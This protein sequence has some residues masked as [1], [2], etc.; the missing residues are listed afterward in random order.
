M[1][2]YKKKFYTIF[3]LFV[4]LWCFPVDVLADIY[5]SC[6]GGVLPEG[7]DTTGT[8]TTGKPYRT[9]QVGI[10]ALKQ[11]GPGNILYLGGGS[12][13][14]IPSGSPW[15]S[16][17]ISFETLNDATSWTNSYTICSYPG[18]WA[19][20]DASSYTEEDRIF[21]F[22]GSDS[23]GG[24]GFIEF[25]RLEIKG[26]HA[27][28]SCAGIRGRGGPYKFRY[29]YIHD[30]T[31]DTGATN[32]AGLQL[33]NGTGDSIIEYCY[34]YGNGYLGV[35]ENSANVAIFG[36]YLY[37]WG[38]QQLN[39][40][41]GF[42]TAR[43]NNIVRYNLFD[44]GNGSGDQKTSVGF[45]H[46]SVQFLAN[47]SD[48]EGVPQDVNNWKAEGDNIHHN[49]FLNHSYAAII[50]KG[51]FT[52][53]HHNIID[54]YSNTAEGIL[55]GSTTDTQRPPWSPVVY[56]NL[57]I[58]TR[59]GV[60]YFNGSGDVYTQDWIL[61]NIID[62]STYY[63]FI[64][65]ITFFRYNSTE[66]WDIDT[67]L[68]INNNIFYRPPDT[69]LIRILGNDYT[70]SQANSNA[71]ASDNYSYEYNESDYLYAAQSG[72]DKYKLNSAYSNFST[73]S[74]G[75]VG[76]VHPYLTGITIPSY[77]GAAN[78]DDNDWVDGVLS[79]ANVS[80]LQNGGSGDPDWIE[81]GQSY[82]CD[83]QNATVKGNF[84]ED[85]VIVE[86]TNPDCS[87]YKGVEIRIKEGSQCVDHTDGYEI[88]DDEES[89]QPN[90]AY[91]YEYKYDEDNFVKGIQYYYSFYTYKV[92]E[93]ER[94]YSHTV[95]IPFPPTPDTP[96]NLKVVDDNGN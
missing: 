26:A 76:G 88:Y 28:L 77:I 29:L 96:T 12:Y 93:S 8:G 45:K 24:Q 34:F 69:T 73:V 14:T 43:H 89:G 81:G 36:D 9:I 30:N 39:N 65:E 67:Y 37:H 54:S 48:N 10:D 17:R 32:P 58:N 56:N 52:Q 18:E 21:V 44:G 40:I 74:A 33:E 60:H 72:A 75:G 6:G 51:D 84:E 31:C 50:D 20:I 59:G 7:N 61:N 27:A 71:W 70:L 68:K 4:V 82:N 90:I 92:V 78:P 64:Q 95:V 79:L 19:V 57:V 25:S 13:T 23:N 5:V 35:N 22:N 15:E 80:Q 2:L 38:D 16:R 85:G 55:G 62:A 66:T 42:S 83:V 11:Q 41:S 46:K 91:S 87:D 49:I 53:I 3:F 47:N 63:S 94:I 86:W 1:N